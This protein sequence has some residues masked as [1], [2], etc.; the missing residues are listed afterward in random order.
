[1]TPKTSR[2]MPG[3]EPRTDSAR[4]TQQAIIEDADKTDNKDRDLVH[5]DGGSIDIPTK[6]DDLSRDD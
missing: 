5:G 4:D 1:M 6:P 3:P 2:N